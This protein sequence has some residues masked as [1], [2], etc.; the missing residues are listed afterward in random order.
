[1]S[2][3]PRSQRIAGAVAAGLLAAGALVLEYI[4]VLIAA[5]TCF[6]ACTERDGWRG[7]AEAWQWDL[8]LA[9]ATAGLMLALAAVPLAATGRG[10][11]AVQALTASAA[12]FGT[13]WA[14][15]TGA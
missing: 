9:W 12:T 5:I 2:A 14:F 4:A 10:R 8:Q 11:R 3:A 6:D 1:M 7:D 15:V 13:W